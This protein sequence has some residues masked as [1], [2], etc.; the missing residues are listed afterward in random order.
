MNSSPPMP[1]ASYVF[2]KSEMANIL[3][4]NKAFSNWCRLTNDSCSII[5][6]L[7]LWKGARIMKTYV[8]YYAVVIRLAPDTLTR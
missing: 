8:V 6:S 2:M 1:E 4:F 5:I 7:V 3:A